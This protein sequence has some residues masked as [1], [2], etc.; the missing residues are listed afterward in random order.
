MVYQRIL[1]NAIVWLKYYHPVDFSCLQKSLYAWIRVSIQ[2]C[3]FYCKISFY[4][5]QLLVSSASSFCLCLCNTRKINPSWLPFWTL[6]FLFYFLMSLLKDKS[7]LL[8]AAIE[9][10]DAI[11]PGNSGLRRWSRSL[12]DRSLMILDVDRHYKRQINVYCQQMTSQELR[13]VLNYRCSTSRLL[14]SRP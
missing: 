9:P 1:V 7:S 14:A 12:I 3:T 6:S 2:V 10:P 5:S 11:S 8:N 13:S 4:R